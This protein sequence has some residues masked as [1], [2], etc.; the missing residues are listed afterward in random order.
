MFSPLIIETARNEAGK[1]RQDEHFELEARMWNIASSN[2]DG[3]DIKQ[4]NRTLTF[5]QSQG[6]LTSQ[7]IES[8]DE[9]FNQPN[10][11]N[12]RK[13]TF[14][15]G[16]VEI[17]EKKRLGRS[18]NANNLKDFGINLNMSVERMS[19]SQAPNEDPNIIRHKKRTSFFV[20]KILR[21]DLTR[22]VSSKSNNPKYEVEIELIGDLS[23]VNY[24]VFQ[25]WVISLAKIVQDSPILYTK[26]QIG[27]LAKWYNSCLGGSI[28]HPDATLDSGVVAQ[29]RDMRLKDLTWDSMIKTRYDVTYK[30][31]G[32]HKNLV[33]SELGIWLIYAPHS[34]RLMLSAEQAQSVFGG[35]R[36]VLD[37]EWYEPTKTFWV[38][39]TM[40]AKSRG[41]I[42][43]QSLDHLTRMET[44][45]DFLNNYSDILS[46]ITGRISIKPKSFWSTFAKSNPSP[47][48]FFSVMRQRFRNKVVLEYNTDGFVFTP[49]EK[50]YN[51]KE[52]KTNKWSILKWKPST[53]LTID[54]GIKRDKEDPN[55]FNIYVVD[56]K[57]EGAKL[58][59]PCVKKDW[60]NHDEWVLFQGNKI[61][62]FSGRVVASDIIE[63]AED[64]SIYEFMFNHTANTFEPLR[65][66]TDKA[67]PNSAYVALDTY[68]LI[69]DPIAPETLQGDTFILMRKYLNRVKRD[70]FS[71]TKV[72]SVLLDIGSGAGGTSSS[73][74]RY[75]HIYSVEPDEKNIIEQ[76]ER[77]KT[78]NLTDKVDIIHAKGEDYNKIGKALGSK[79]VDVVSLMLSMSFM[80]ES[81]AMVN[82]LAKTIKNAIADHGQI[83]FMTI[84]GD[85]VD[86]LFSP[87][88]NNTKSS[89][90]LR[91]PNK[92]TYDLKKRTIHFHLEG[93]IADHY[94]EYPV[95]IDDLLLALGPEYELTDAFQTDKELFL[96]FEEKVVSRMYLAGIIQKRR[97]KEKIVINEL[98]D[99]TEDLS[100]LLH[101]G[102]PE[103]PTKI[104][105]VVDEKDTMRPKN[106]P[107]ISPN[108]KIKFD[109]R[110]D[111][112]AS[113]IVT[114]KTLGTI[115]HLNVSWYGGNVV[116]IAVIGD[117]SCFFHGYLDAYYPPYQNTKTI[118]GRIKIVTEVR[119]NLAKILTNKDR[120]DK[121]KTNYESSEVY[122]LRNVKKFKNEHN[123]YVDYSLEGFKEML[124]NTSIFVGDEVYSYVAK[125]MGP[126]VIIMRGTNKDV[127]YHTRTHIKDRN[128][129]VLIGTINHYELLGIDNED[130]KIQTFFDSD[131]PFIVSLIENAKPYPLNEDAIEIIE[132]LD[133]AEE[134]KPKKLDLSPRP[135]SPLKTRGI[136]GSPLKKSKD[137]S[138]SVTQCIARTKANKRCSR[139]AV[140]GTKYCKQHGDH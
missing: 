14:N 60:R 94:D 12:L 107:I 63:N 88:M 27:H 139:D 8:K 121:T 108:K 95:Y 29:A 50:P 28:N 90:E 21:L 51:Y 2:V 124:K 89:F 127:Y 72:G 71:S 38:F 137:N 99:D 5:L 9:I 82:N 37:G 109:V 48:E 10:Y 67:K 70:L 118:D 86:Q 115:D 20:G 41:D 39:D 140:N 128:Y 79:K 44:A 66:R 100:Q 7:Y 53:D 117:G 134:E 22:V 3:V 81:Q 55:Y 16:R 49:I 83:I 1:L 114:Q 36:I 136:K 40:L 135:K 103:N 98:P 4:Y 130:G 54:F 112:L 47:D 78:F 123:Q 111:P 52:T 35:D 6:S 64:G 104:K 133:E 56:K 46:K 113:M 138:T 15:D 17:S 84:N 42:G 45:Q 32:V 131:D 33:I 93:T 74:S 73:W 62:P 26:N 91:P 122:D 102:N 105:Y 61:K 101:I 25:T 68:G 24:K 87:L 30:T 58:N 119:E 76:K 106:S 57:S 85:A 132:P 18:S 11:W 92:F 96:S 19:K 80:W 23:D 97:Y 129:V 75:S 69:H 110:E 59:L 120:E 43:V 34:F 65:A 31:D 125:N 116:R 77:L 13:T 126:N